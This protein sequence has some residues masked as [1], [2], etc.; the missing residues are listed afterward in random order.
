[1]VHFFRRRSTYY[2]RVIVPTDLRAILLR[3]EIRQSLKT[4]SRRQ[5]GV[6]A[7]K[8]A[9]NVSELFKAVRGGDMPVTKADVNAL[10]SRYLNRELDGWEEE[11]VNGRLAG[12]RDTVGSILADRLE[13]VTTQLVNADYR[14]VKRLAVSLLAETRLPGLT[15]TSPDF[16]RLCHLLL[17]A[18]QRIYRTEIDR[19]EGTWTANGTV[20]SMAVE[21]GPIL[22]VSE[23]VKK[24]I[25]HYGHRDERTNAEKLVILK[26]FMETLPSGGAAPLN[27]IKK[28]EVIAFRDLYAQSPS[29]QSAVHRGKTLPALVKM[30]NGKGTKRITKATVN[31]ALTDLRHFFVWAMRHDLYL[32]PRNPVDGVDLEGEVTEHFEAYDDHELVAMFTHP[33]FLEQRETYPARYWLPYVLLYTGARREEIARLS[34]QKIQRDPSGI[35]YFDIKTDPA[36]SKKGKNEYSRRRVPVHS[37]LIELGFLDYVEAHKRRPILLVKEQGCGVRSGKGRDTVGDSVS[38]WHAIL[39]GKIGLTGKKALHS[40][41]DTLITRLVSLGV[42]EDIRKILVG[43]SANDVHGSVYVKRDKVALTLLQEHLEKLKYPV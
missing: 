5:A 23:A 18:Q 40:F 12:D 38:K 34:P 43:H 24:Y 2:A 15:I 10:V 39:R 9:G 22:P 29:R 37:R 3:R 4:D 16:P 17:R 41:R 20:E 36:T 8:F 6:L 35:V 11:H 14:K 19:L 33:Y 27:R 32:D 28:P 26:R 1:M 25:Q 30:L 31:H 13:D 7:G 21:E 42:P